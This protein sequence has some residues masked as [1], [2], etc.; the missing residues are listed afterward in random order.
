MF[1][2]HFEVIFVF[3]VDVLAWTFHLG[4][5]QCSIFVDVVIGPEDWVA[6]G[7]F[8]PFND[9]HSAV[10]PSGS[11]STDE[12]DSVSQSKRADLY[13]STVFDPVF[14]TFPCILFFN[15]FSPFQLF[16]HLLVSSL[17]LFDFLLLSGLF[18]EDI[19]GVVHWTLR[20]EVFFAVLLPVLLIQLID[21]LLYISPHEQE[22]VDE[23]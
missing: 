10:V 2:R 3:L 22:I 1:S 19:H 18:V 21:A 7:L 6:L 12:D 4:V 5:S 23:F 13:I 16:F 15:L 8:I 17:F 9:K 20:H 14:L 11:V